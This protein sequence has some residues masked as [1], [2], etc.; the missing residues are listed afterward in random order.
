MFTRKDYMEKRCTHREYYAQFVTDEIRQH[1]AKHIGTDQLRAS[2]DE[3]LNDIP[4]RRWDHLPLFY[5]SDHEKVRAAGDW[6]SPA[7]AVCIYKEAAR[8]L[9]EA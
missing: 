1:V 3:H 6:I 4:L 2:T 5:K 9:I 7:G 8:Q